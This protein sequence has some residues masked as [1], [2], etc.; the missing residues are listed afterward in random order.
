MN[1]RQLRAD[2]HFSSEQPLLGAAGT[3]E[4]RRPQVPVVL[5]FLLASSACAGVS[6]TG[7][8]TPPAIERQAMGNPAFTDTTLYNEWNLCGSPLGMLDAEN[9]DMRFSLGF[10]S[11]N[12]S[13]SGDSMSRNAQ[14]ASL[15]DILVG[16]REVMYLR[17][18]YE[19]SWLSEKSDAA[20]TAL[21]P[22]HRF[23]LMSAAQTPG[24]YFRFGVLAQGFVGT[25]QGTTG[26]SAT[27]THLGLTA[28][29]A[30]LGS[31]VHPLVRIGIRGGVTA[32]L[33]SLRDTVGLTE[34]RFFYGTIP[35]YGGDISVGG[36]SLPVRSILSLDVAQNHFVYVAK[37][38]AAPDGNEDAVVADSLYASWNTVGSIPAFAGIVC[39]PALSLAFMRSAVNRRVPGDKNYP[40]DYG[41]VRSDSGWTISCFTL[42]AGSAVTMWNYGRAFLEYGHD[43]FGLSYEKGVGYP[44]SQR[45][46]DRIALGLEANIHAIPALRIP[47][48]IEIFGRLGYVNIRTDSRFG[49]YYGDEFRDFTALSSGALRSGSESPYR[50]TLGGDVRISRFTIGT[51]ATFFNR[52][53]GVDLLLG[54]CSLMQ[55]RPEGA[56][57]FGVNAFYAIGAKKSGM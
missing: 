35:T 2:A 22:L 50:P 8:V 27:R 15:P 29:S 16:K 54:F 33:D 51:G 44:N 11:Y 21:S 12:E 14:V 28:L 34:D 19:P 57:E 39:Q 40:L 30:Y 38:S 43:F 17:L 42:G 31:Q 9:A 48:S 24:K 53:A 36:G 41:P 7:L 56:M 45:G 3:G 46:F 26:Q 20:G 1:A 6:E 5:L 32:A 55:S 25:Q 52:T 13:G 47:Q 10:K 37:P 49:A 4:G 18:F 23:G